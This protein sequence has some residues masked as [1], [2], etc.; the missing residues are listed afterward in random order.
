MKHFFLI[1]FV[2]FIPA[3]C[4]A[5]SEHVRV[6]YRDDGVSVMSLVSGTCRNLSESD[7]FDR[8]MAK[9]DIGQ[10]PHEDILKSQLPPE[11]TNFD[12]WRGAPGQGVHVDTTLVTKDEK[13]AELQQK[14][15]AELA[16][17]APSSVVVAKLQRLI[18]KLDSLKTK[19]TVL[20]S[21]ELEKFND[22][23]KS[24]LATVFGALKDAF[25]S[26]VGS[27]SSA[28]ENGVLA[29]RDVV[30]N[31]LKIG[32]REKPAGITVYDQESGEPYCLVVKGGLPTSIPG[33][34]P[35]ATETS[36]STPSIVGNTASTTVVGGTDAATG[37]T[38]TQAPEI[39]I[40][41]NN[42]AELEKGESYSDLG[43]TVTDNMDRNPRLDVAGG[44]IDTSEPGDYTVT[45]TATDSAGNRATAT[46][47]VTV[48]GKKDKLVKPEGA[49]ASSTDLNAS[50]TPSGN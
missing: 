47:A 2:F 35:S 29:I 21:D 28:I 5:E 3:T 46:R 7:C 15:D 45:Y 31:T 42:P 26:V 40:N 1:F 9:S 14:L 18:Q 6:F 24:L 11:D 30:T 49:D 22:D 17:N 19:T 39:K 32:S 20:S 12:K 27:I 16:K 25:S 38:D 34:C 33:E 41:G 43:A 13:K 8:E 48:K 50:S 36:S 10:Y 44:E 37:N 4:F 23:N